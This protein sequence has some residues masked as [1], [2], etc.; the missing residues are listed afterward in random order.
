M[1]NVKRYYPISYLKTNASDVA[2]QLTE[3]TD[4]LIFTQNGVPVFVCVSMEEY[5]QTKETNALLRMLTFSER[6]IKRGNVKSLQQAKAML[7]KSLF[8]DEE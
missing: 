1:A 4:S 5:H 3:E 2:R 6:E 7:D 8:G